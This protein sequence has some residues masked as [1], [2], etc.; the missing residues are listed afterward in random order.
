M[1]WRL[2]FILQSVFSLLLAT[3]CI[4]LPGSPRWL[5]LNGQRAQALK[6]IDR[7][8]IS[9]VEAEK[10][11][12]TVQHESTETMSTLEGFLMIFKR[13]YRSKTILALF[14]LGMVQL[15]GIDG[16]LYVSPQKS[17]AMTSKRTNI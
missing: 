3:F 16:V 4:F 2:P 13:T 14:M 1:S 9:A 10:I 6:E 17:R 11:V 8:N 7:L 15:S 12:S 5:I